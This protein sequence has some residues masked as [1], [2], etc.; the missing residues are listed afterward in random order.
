VE[1]AF[2][3]ANPTNSPSKEDVPLAHST[4]FIT[5]PLT[6][7]HAQLDSTWIAMVFANSLLLRLSPAPMDN[8]LTPILVVRLVAQLAKHA[9]QPTIVLHALQVGSLLTLKDSV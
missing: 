4:P 7:A 9:N 5:M 6:A 8:T 3:L 1:F 2:Y